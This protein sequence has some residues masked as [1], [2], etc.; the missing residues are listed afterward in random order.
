MASIT[1]G[2]IQSRGIQA[3]AS[4]EA[5]FINKRGDIMRRRG[6]NLA[7]LWLLK[8]RHLPRRPAAAGADARYRRRRSSSWC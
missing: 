4:I 6:V 7:A 2:E 8:A 1:E 3:E 5:N